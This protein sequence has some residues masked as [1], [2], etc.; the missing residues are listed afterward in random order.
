MSCASPFASVKEFIAKPTGLH[1][2]PLLA[3]WANRLDGGAFY[4]NS[5]RYA[6]DLQLGNVSGP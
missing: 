4:A 1:G 3:P 6:L 2:I 5:R